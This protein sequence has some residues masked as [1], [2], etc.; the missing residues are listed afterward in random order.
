MSPT[1]LIFHVVFSP[2]FLATTIICFTFSRGINSSAYFASL[3]P[4]LGE[5]QEEIKKLGFEVLIVEVMKSLYSR[6]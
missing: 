1:S 3:S 4:S 6:K 5:N 2:V